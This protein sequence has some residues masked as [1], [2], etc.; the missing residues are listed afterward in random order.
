[1]SF[2]I[3]GLIVFL[4]LALGALIVFFLKKALN[5]E[6]VD[7]TLERF[8]ALV[9]DDNLAKIAEIKLRFYS[10]LSESAQQRVKRTLERKFPQAK[11][12]LEK[13][14]SIKGGLVLELGGVRVDGS[15]SDRLNH[16]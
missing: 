5:K 13:D 15:L 16:I 7:T 4:Q 2:G 10:Q 1:M 6:L 14:R 12:I 9:P 3:I 8:E 11:L